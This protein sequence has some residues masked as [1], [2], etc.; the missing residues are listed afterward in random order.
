MNERLPVTDDL[1]EQM[2]RR[3]ANRA[4]LTDLLDLTRDE[5][6]GTTQRRTSSDPIGRWLRIVD[7]PRAF[8]GLAAV[9]AVI[10]ASVIGVALLGAPARPGAGV[11]APSPSPSPS[12]TRPPSSS[13][14]EA[15]YPRPLPAGT[16][17]AESFWPTLTMT[18]PDGWITD[19]GS[20]SFLGLVP[21]AD[22]NAP[23]A[24][25]D[26]F[27]NL[28]VAAEDCAE[29]AEP[30]IGSTASDIVGALAARPGLSVSEPV[31]VTIGG[32]SGGQIDLELAR[33]WTGTCPA[34]EGPF[35]PLV[36]EEGFLWWGAA[37]GERF[38]IIVLDVAPLPSGM[39]ATVM[40]FIYGQDAAV[41]SDHLAASM[42]IVES[43]A[44]DVDG[45][46]Q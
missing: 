3:R 9:V 20:G 18:I 5:V 4:T 19:G 2:L 25:L 22:E 8:A 14:S 40:I 36:H 38:R 31:P 42:A 11:A 37:P 39:S 1:I 17:T 33:G 12:P 27:L 45:P 43:F 28:S 32:L 24:F 44:F 35:V 23:V 21:E 46:P 15:A 7:V 16:F 10:A 13:P 29:A 41:W 26:V 6:T 30:D 34:V